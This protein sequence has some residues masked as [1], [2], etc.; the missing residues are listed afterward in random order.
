MSDLQPLQLVAHIYGEAG[1][2][3]ASRHKDGNHNEL[4]ALARALGAY[5]IETHIVG[6]GCPDIFAFTRSTGWLA[7][8]IKSAKG[9][10][11]EGQ[12][13]LQ[14]RVPVVVWRTAAD[15]CASFGVTGVN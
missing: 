3:R 11:R 8:E 7:V 10:L 2:R 14:Q 15:V 9:Q 1:M 4:V 13:K 12:I 5:V 6:R